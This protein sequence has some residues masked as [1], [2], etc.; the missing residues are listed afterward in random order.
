MSRGAV[1]SWSFGAGTTYNKGASVDEAFMARR[2]LGLGWGA[3]FLLF[4]AVGAKAADF[5]SGNELWGNCQDPN[6][7]QFSYGYILVTAQTYSI[8]RPMKSQPFFLHCP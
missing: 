5:V 4:L 2:F 8:T 1:K 3:V 7:L 6:K